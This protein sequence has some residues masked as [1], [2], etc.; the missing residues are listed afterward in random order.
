[1]VHSSLPPAIDLETLDGLRLLGGG[2]D[3]GFE[4]IK[5][6]FHTETRD[7]LTRLQA[8]FDAADRDQM[9]RLSHSLRGICG[10]MGATRM[11]DLTQVLENAA[12]AGAP[13]SPGI[14]V[15]LEQEFARVCAA[16]E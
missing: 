8:A 10:A 5:R 15:E 12:R 11:S 2:A 13:L 1:M 9:S 4:L 3:D 7:R 14:I 6:A 16:L